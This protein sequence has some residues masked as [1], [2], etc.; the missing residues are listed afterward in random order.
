MTMLAGLATSNLMPGTVNRH[1]GDRFL[2]SGQNPNI[3]MLTVR[4]APNPQQP[5]LVLQRPD[6]FTA[7]SFD[8]NGQLT[9]GGTDPAAIATTTLTINCYSVSNGSSFTS[10]IAT[11]AGGS[12]ILTNGG[13]GNGNM[14]C[15]NGTIYYGIGNSGQATQAAFTVSATSLGRSPSLC[16][17][18]STKT[19][20]L[21]ASDTNNFGPTEGGTPGTGVVSAMQGGGTDVTGGTLVL[22]GGQGTGAGVG[23]NLLFKTSMAGST[24]ATLNTLAT[25]VTISPTTQNF[26][27]AATAATLLPFVIKGAALQSADLT[28]W[29]TNG[30]AVLFA[31]DSLGRPYTANTTPTI[32]AG[33]GAGTSPTIAISGTDV[34]GVVTLTTGALP[35][36]SAVVATITFSAAYAT[37]PK[38]VQLLNADVNSAALSGLTMVW[39]PVVGDTNGVTT[40]TWCLV[41]GATGL[42]AATS[43]KWRYF[44]CG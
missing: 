11:D 36:G 25:V 13:G 18:H 39:V 24:S 29:L 20:W 28:R 42:V 26:L 17:I 21:G 19:L 23:G 43:Y 5:T 15:T 14:L 1:Q 16:Y 44:V 3:P 35:T 2:I 10:T 34:N 27:I 31:H 41:A 7:A 8:K 4:P 40:T 12:L 22:S 32:A 38:T 33:T 37:A 9:L 6:R 30:S